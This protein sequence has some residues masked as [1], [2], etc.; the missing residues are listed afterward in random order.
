MPLRRLLRGR[1]QANGLGH[2]EWGFLRARSDF[3][4]ETNRRDK[5]A[6]I[7]RVYDLLSEELYQRIFTWDRVASRSVRVFHRVLKGTSGPYI[8][9]ELARVVATQVERFC[10]GPQAFE[11]RS[12]YRLPGNDVEY[13]FEFPRL[14]DPEA[15]R[16][17]VTA[18]AHQQLFMRYP[19][20]RVLP[21]HVL[22]AVVLAEVS[23]RQVEPLQEFDFAS[24]L[25]RI[26]KRSN[27][28]EEAR[29]VQGEV[30]RN[31]GPCER[32]FQRLA[33]CCR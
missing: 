32:T 26:P 12:W 8:L 10:D 23:W 17:S 33:D 6:P 2:V 29:P 30:R 9:P 21:N 13:G 1:H 4:A 15:K 19:E 25:R 16:E 11:G 22:D 18:R 7:T 28:M 14:D 31:G 24:S 20:F 5:A 3:I 27:A